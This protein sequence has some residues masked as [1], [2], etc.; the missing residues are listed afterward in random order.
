LLCFKASTDQIIDLSFS[1][2][3]TLL[4]PPDEHFKK[5]AVDLFASFKL[6]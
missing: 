6:K 3:N 5:A 1:E 4:R 2:L